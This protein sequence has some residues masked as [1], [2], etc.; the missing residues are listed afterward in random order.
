[1]IAALGCGLV[2]CLWQPAT[3]AGA[4]AK[5]A[6]PALRIIVLD[7]E[8]GKP[9]PSF[10]LIAGSDINPPFPALRSGP[11]PVSGAARQKQIP[12]STGA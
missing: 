7:E 6:P 12:S 5:D 10:R 11:T 8:T 3:A 1:M 2:Q 9:I 4:E